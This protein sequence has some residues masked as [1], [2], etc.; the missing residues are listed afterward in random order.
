MA[1][2]LVAICLINITY[3][4]NSRIVTSLK[5]RLQHLFHFGSNRLANH[6]RLK[7]LLKQIKLAPKI[8]LETRVYH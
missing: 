7:E 1:A 2:V 6:L 3:R 8:R 4:L 5:M